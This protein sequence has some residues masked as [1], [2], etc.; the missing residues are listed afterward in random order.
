M[1][2]VCCT[3]WKRFSRAPTS[4]LCSVYFLQSE[5]CCCSEIAQ[6]RA[7]T[8]RSGDDVPRLQSGRQLN[9]EGFWPHLRHFRKPVMLFCPVRRFFLSWMFST[10]LKPFVDSYVLR[11]P[12][13]LHLK[14]RA[15]CCDLICTSSW[16]RRKNQVRNSQTLAN[17]WQENS[18]AYIS[19]TACLHWD[20]HLIF[21]AKEML[22][23]DDLTLK[24]SLCTTWEQCSFWCHA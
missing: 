14:D 4:A 23:T 24:I 8:W 22:S 6:D 12:T 15:L 13:R 16:Y 11:L 10:V 1:I 2:I 18:V 5:L 21:S 3:D 7:E 19:K 20:L 9:C 17:A